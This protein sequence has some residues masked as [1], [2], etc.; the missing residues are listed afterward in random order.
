MLANVLWSRQEWRD[1]GVHAYICWLFVVIVS[2][3]AVAVS[4]VVPVP[5]V[6]EGA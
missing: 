2:A 1:D 6:L 5:V 4:V 3:V